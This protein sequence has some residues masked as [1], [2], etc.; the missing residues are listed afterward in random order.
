[1]IRLLRTKLIFIFIT[2]AICCSHVKAQT[3]NCS[4]NNCASPVVH[5]TWGY[6]QWQVDQGS[7][8]KTGDGATTTLK[9]ETGFTT[10]PPGGG[11]ST[12]MFNLLATRTIHEIHGMVAFTVWLGGSCGVGSIIAEVHDQAGN[13]I[14]SAYLQNL[15]TNSVINLPIKGTFPAGLSVSGLQLASYSSQCAATTLSWALV[16]N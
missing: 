10:A 4:N 16:M 5:E 6:Y 9:S 14:A 11:F 7:P 3:S 2:A 8:A 1:M 12:G 15:T 13:T